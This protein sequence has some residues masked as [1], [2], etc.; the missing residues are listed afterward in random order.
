MNNLSNKERI[1][2][3][4][5]YKKIE[6]ICNFNLY[7]KAQII[8]LYTFVLLILFSIFYLVFCIYTNNYYIY[9]LCFFG[10]FILLLISITINFFIFLNKI[11]KNISKNINELYEIYYA[12]KNNKNLKF[13]T[14]SK[15]TQKRGVD[16]IKG[17]T[18]YYYNQV[19]EF[20]DSIE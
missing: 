18:Q 19:V 3:N 10:A 11:K 2:D 13:K 1:I 6:I 12:K 7:K 9:I 20:L 8:Y 14:T 15:Y 4:K 16:P 5:L 17:I